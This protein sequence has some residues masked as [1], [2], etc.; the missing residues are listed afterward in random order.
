MACRALK[1]AKG[2][3]LDISLPVPGN[4]SIGSISTR[5][6]LRSGVPPP[7]TESNKGSSV[8]VIWQK[9]ARRLSGVHPEYNATA[10]G[11]GPNGYTR[12]QLSAALT[13][14]QCLFGDTEESTTSRL[15]GA[16]SLLPLVY[17]EA[18]GPKVFPGHHFPPYRMPHTANMRVDKPTVLVE[19]N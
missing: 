13:L 18:C 19:K 8:P 2:D 14:Q 5:E 16:G 15:T 12:H 11:R 17:S 10:S 6:N 4:G 1:I 9:Q 3:F 7:T